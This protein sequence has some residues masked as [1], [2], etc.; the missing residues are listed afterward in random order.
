MPALTIAT[1]ALTAAVVWWLRPAAPPPPVLGQ[2]PAWT[3]LD[4]SGEAFGSA[5]LKGRVWVASFFFTSCQSICPKILGAMAKVQTRFEADELPVLLTS[6][7]VDPQTDTPEVLAAFEPRYKIDRQR[8]RL[9]T[10]ERPAIRALVVDGFKTY[11]GDKVQM[12]DN[13][14]DISHGA[15]LV[16]VDGQGGVRGHYETDDAGL[17]AL[18]RDASAVSDT[19]R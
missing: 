12:S 11:M 6:I 7:T 3:L 18:F 5:Q 1:L 2:V 19:A 15:R 8:W 9:L 14:V 4:A 13:L 10:G 16:L 17:E